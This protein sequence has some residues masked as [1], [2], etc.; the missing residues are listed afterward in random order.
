ML[1]EHIIIVNDFAYVD[2]GASQVALL[3]AKGLAEKGLN[4]TLFSAVDSPFRDSVAEKPKFRSVSTH[5]FEILSDPNRL[6]ASV[7][8]LWNQVAQKRF[9]ELL[10]EINSDTTVIHIHG[11]T[12]A[13]SSSIV[14]TALMMKF[15]VVVTVHDYFLACPNGAFYNYPD[16]HIC[17]LP[18]LSRSCLLENCDSR[19]YYHK[20]WRFG[21]TLVQKKFGLLPD[22]IR[23]FIVL[24]DF[25]LKIMKPYLPRHA[26][27][28]HLDNPIEFPKIPP[29]NVSKNR[30]YLAVGRIAEEKGPHLFAQAAA[31]LNLPA[32]FV[33]DGSFR[34][35]VSEIY[36]SAV[37][38]G[39]VNQED[40]I[41]HLKSARALVFASV[42]YENQPLVVLEAASMGIPVVVADTNAA[43]EIVV[44]GETGLWFKGGHVGDLTAKLKL[45]DDPNYVGKLG[46]SAYE[47]Y[48]SNPKSLEVHTNNLLT[49]YTKILSA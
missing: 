33:G 11:W 24:S 3:S 19:N 26:R 23:D 18:P 14:R 40:V 46:R 21:R 8:G 42:L 37:I 12:K 32:V 41:R 49:I 27:I 10:K 4:V 13:L 31:K 17:H 22:G 29:V 44:D 25:N 5:Q 43:K 45:L 48:W 6:R 36:P 9:S 1:P 2:G 15:K 38:T 39:W 34:D 20:L 35:S 16:A 7:Q 47:K 30:N 28:F